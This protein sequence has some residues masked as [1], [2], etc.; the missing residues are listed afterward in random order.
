MLTPGWRRRGMPLNITTLLTL[1][2]VRIRDLP[3]NF[4]GNKRASIDKR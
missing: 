1:F 2:W 3:H 4:L